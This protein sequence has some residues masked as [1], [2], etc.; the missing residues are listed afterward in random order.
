MVLFND[1]THSLR[2]GD[3]TLQKG[4][5]VRTFEVKAS[6]KAYQSREAARQIEIPRSIHDYIKTDVM[7]Y[8][9]RFS[10]VPGVVQGAVRLDSTVKED[11]HWDIAG[12]LHKALRKTSVAHV[13]R[14]GKHYFAARRRDIGEL[15]SVLHMMTASGDWVVSNI[16]RRVEA[17]A[18]VSPFTQWFKL[19]SSV[20]IMAGDLIVLSGFNIGDLELLFA[21]KGL[22]TTWKRKMTDLFPLRICGAMDTGLIPDDCFNVGDHQRLKLMYGFLAIES[23]V[24]IVAFLLSREAAAQMT[25]KLRSSR[26][27]VAESSVR[28]FESQPGSDPIQ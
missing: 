14:G 22:R 12:Q 5:E 9:H 6:P 4:D 28:A 25:E 1:L 8:P 13:V 21:E 3:L 2:V 18:E 17:L 20:E 19:E 27:E 23:F 7:D 24:D 15:S 11:W 16:Q 26:L 10:G